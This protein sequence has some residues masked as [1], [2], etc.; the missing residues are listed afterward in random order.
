MASSIARYDGYADWYE[1]NFRPTAEAMRDD[2]ARWL[3]PGEGPCLD[4]GCGTGLYFDVVRRTGRTPVGLDRSADQLRHARGRG[5]CLRG[6]GAALPFA[7]GVFPTVLMVWVSTDVD[8]FTAAVGETA[9]VLRPGGLL[10]F[11]GAHPCFMGPHISYREDGGRT[12]PP[13]YRRSGWH[14]EQ[15]WWRDRHG[16]RHR[17]GM[18][19]VPLAE[20]L[21]A[22]LDVGLRLEDVAEPEPHHPVPISLMLRLRA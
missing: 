1:E 19:H 20:L 13:T 9:R 8:D 11:F 14:P 5:T 3:G 2:V 6:D 18:R 17:V 15:P 4:L 12:I 21:R 22:F 7:T 16:L 10:L